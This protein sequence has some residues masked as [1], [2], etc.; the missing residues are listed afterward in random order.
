MPSDDLLLY[1]A[2]DFAIENHWRVNGTHYGRTSEDWL[3]NLDSNKDEA[4]KLLGDTYGTEN[5]MERYVQWRV[6]FMACAELF[7]FNKGESWFVSH[8]LFRKR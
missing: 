1:F 6:F 5:A 3:K 4:L 7:N 2:N 8:Y